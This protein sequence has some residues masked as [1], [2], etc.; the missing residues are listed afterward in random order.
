LPGYELLNL[1]TTG[2]F[3][4]AW[5]LGFSLSNLLDQQF[6]ETVGVPDPGLSF[7]AEVRYSC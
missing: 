3:V 2:R 6:E 1:A 4:R 5:E 7:R